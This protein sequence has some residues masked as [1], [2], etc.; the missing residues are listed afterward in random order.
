[1]CKITRR[2]IMKLFPT[3]S[4][5]FICL[6]KKVSRITTLTIVL[7]TCFTTNI[8]IPAINT[9][10]ICLVKKVIRITT[11]TIVLVTRYTTSIFFPASSAILILIYKSTILTFYA[12]L[13]V[14]FSAIPIEICL[15]RLTC[16]G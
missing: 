1:M 5:L 13:Y 12:P 10:F 8:F 15:A 7:V 16:V 3:R 9:L 4:T 6:I 14:A 11:L 2:T